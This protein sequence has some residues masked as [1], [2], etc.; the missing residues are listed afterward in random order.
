MNADIIRSRS[1]VVLFSVWFA[2]LLAACDGGISGTGDGGPIIVDVDGDSG[3]VAESDH[4]AGD[5]ADGLVSAGISI[6]LDFTS[7]P[8]TNALAL[9]TTA[10]DDTGQYANGG[11]VLSELLHTRIR[12]YDDS[13]AQVSVHT[14]ALQRE[15]A[16]ILEQ[17]TGGGICD[18]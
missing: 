8:L 17:C 15:L 5:T 13:I 3:T 7:A 14:A 18:A 9:T 10:Q 2:V 11:A 12:R 16:A 1:M 4:A 6:P